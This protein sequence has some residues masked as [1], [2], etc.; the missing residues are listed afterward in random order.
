MRIKLFFFVL[1][2]IL[3]NAFAVTDK[4]RVQDEAN[5]LTYDQKMEI[6]NKLREQSTR[7]DADLF[8]ITRNGLNGVA[9][10]QYA[11]DYFFEAE[12]GGPSGTGAVFII[13]MTGRDMG[14]FTFG[15][16]IPLFEHRMDPTLDHLA[17]MLTNQQYYEAC[18]Y[19]IDAMEPI[20]FFGGMLK[21]LVNYKTLLIALVLTAIAY[22]ILSRKPSNGK[23][24]SNKTYEVAGSF[25]LSNKVD[26]YTHTTETRTKIQSSSSGSSGSSSSGGGGSSGGGSRSF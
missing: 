6:D 23:A 11:E 20:T 3:Q 15:K 10:R 4:L 25:A 12:N 14:V 13:D 24:V 16:Y 17:P 5:L 1:A 19:Y 2:I 18:L 7:N 8:F 22:F 26:L 21:A 9:T